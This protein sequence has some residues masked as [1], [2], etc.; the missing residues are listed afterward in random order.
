MKTLVSLLQKIGFSR[1]HQDFLSRLSSNCVRP[2]VHWVTIPPPTSEDK[3]TD[4]IQLTEASYCDTLV[5]H[6]RDLA[7]K[8][9]KM[10]NPN[11]ELLKINDFLKEL[12]L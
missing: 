3:I 2:I 11:I 10:L 5:S 9:G 1:C 4:A 12:G 6:D 7:N 8:Y